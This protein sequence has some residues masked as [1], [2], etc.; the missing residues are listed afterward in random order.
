MKNIYINPLFYIISLILLITGFF[1]FFLYIMIYLLVHEFGHIIV[2]Y[3]MGFKIKKINIYPCGLLTIFDMKINESNFKNLI[4]SISGPFFQCLC[5]LVLKKY[6]SIH[7]FLLI[8]NLLPIYPLDG[9]KIVNSFLYLLFPYKMCNNIIFFI[10]YILS[11]FILIYYFFN[12]NLFILIIFILLF[13]K[14]IEFYKNKDYLFNL[15]LLE[16]ILYKFNFRFFKK[17]KNINYMYM[18]RYH[19]ILVDDK[20]VDENYYLKY[21]YD[22]KK[23]V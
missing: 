14:V 11:L 5:Y 17:I 1:K 9:S 19:Y 13:I 2:A 3:L 23:R 18:N 8:L 6:Y 10:S 7:M 12:F 21:F 15:F 16:R 4:I 20:Y 22:L